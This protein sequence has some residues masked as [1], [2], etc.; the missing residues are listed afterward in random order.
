MAQ[1]DNSYLADKVMLRAL[2]LPD[3]DKISVLDCYGGYGVVWDWVKRI[4][5][6]DISVLS[7]DVK[8]VGYALPGNNMAYLTNIDLGRF[9]VIDLDAYGAPF[10]QLDTVLDRGFQGTIFVTFIQIVVGELP[11]KMLESIGFPLA[12]VRKCPTLFF[13]KGWEKMLQ[14]LSS[15]GYDTVTHRSHGRKHYFVINGAEALSGDYDSREEDTVAGH[16]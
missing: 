3:G 13:R 14:Y 9:D 7:I 2:H 8:D 10:E 5:E 6:R 4:S 11:Y 15:R 1:T 12:A 16:S